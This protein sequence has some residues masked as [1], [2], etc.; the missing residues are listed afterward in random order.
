MRYIWIRLLLE[1]NWQN[2]SRPPPSTF[3]PFSLITEWPKVV[4]QCAKFPLR[5]RY[6]N[7]C[8]WRLDCWDSGFEFRWG[9][10]CSCLVLGP[11]R[12]ADHSLRAV[13]PDVCLNCASYRN[14]NN[15]TALDRFGLLRNRKK[16]RYTRCSNFDPAISYANHSPWFSSV[17]KGKSS[18]KTKKISFHILS[19]LLFSWSDHSTLDKRSW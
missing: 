6:V 10:G 7:Q 8:R 12:W 18:N 5:I 9:N 11:L 2:R 19:N 13:Q 3:V 4:V 15:E 14:L 17:P 16:N 1:I